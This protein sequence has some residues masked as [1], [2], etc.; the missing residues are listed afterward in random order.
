MFCRKKRR[1]REVKS[2][3]QNMNRMAWMRKYDWLRTCH[4]MDDMLSP[5]PSIF[6]LRQTYLRDFS[7][8]P[9]LACALGLCMQDTFARATHSAKRARR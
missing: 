4:V 6:K 7:K 5:K 9:L 8:I 1:P 3:K 2:K